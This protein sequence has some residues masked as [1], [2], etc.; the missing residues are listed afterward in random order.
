MKKTL[1]ILSILFLFTLSSSAAEAVSPTVTE[2]VSPTK[3]KVSPTSGN[4]V[5]GEK[6]DEQINELKEKIASRVSELKLVEK[7]AIIG[8]VSEVTTNKITLTDIAGKTRHIDVDEITKFSSPG[9]KGSF[10]LS[11]ITK[12][13]RISALG[14]YNK[15]SKRILAR[16][17]E[18]TVTPQFVSG[19][20]FSIDAK[21]FQLMMT[22]EDQKKIKIDIVTTTKLL[23]YSKGEELTKLGFSKLKVGDRINVI[24][25]FDKKDK[26]MIVASRLIDFL[27]LP[28]NPKVIVAQPT[29]EEEDVVVSTGSGKKLTPI[30]N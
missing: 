2:T 4:K 23:S 1:L 26:S 20:I 27:D 7:R 6:L 25:Y 8:V 16:F 19:A 10:G 5:L 18:V 30:K 11:D 21:N 15:Q 9:V 22:T 28:K 14:L 17:I 12:G 24:G 3:A 29:V 13:T